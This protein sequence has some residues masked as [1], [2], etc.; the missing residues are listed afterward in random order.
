MA[1]ILVI[2]DDQDVREMLK[3]LLERN[4][5]EV[6]IAADGK[7]G[8]DL[9]R[10]EPADVVITDIIMPE[11]EGIE[12]ILE[13]QKD[14]LDIKIIA[15]SGGGMGMAEDYLKAASN[16]ANVKYTFTKPFDHD[17][18]LRAIEELVSK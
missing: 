4:N 12:T 16:L 1:R 7:E 11:K 9:Y 15:I 14:F 17:E 18:M 13:L 2:E 6:L 8:T 3:T 5:Y 10:K